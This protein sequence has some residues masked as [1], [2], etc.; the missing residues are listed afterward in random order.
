MANDR[1]AARPTRATCDS[2]QHAEVPE[3]IRSEGVNA[4]I[5]DFTEGWISSTDLQKQA[6]RKASFGERTV[7]TAFLCSWRTTFGGL[8]DKA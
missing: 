6:T 3:S 1:H 7:E 4:A 5:L 8:R 2:S